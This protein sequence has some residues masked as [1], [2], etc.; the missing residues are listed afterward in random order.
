MKLL[1][2]SEIPWTGLTVSDNKFCLVFRARQNSIA[3]L[4]E[5]QQTQQK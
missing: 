2:I 1:S 3:E 5:F 4:K